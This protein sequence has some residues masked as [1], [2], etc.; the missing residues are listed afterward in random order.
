MHSFTS[1]LLVAL[2]GIVVSVLATESKVRG[3]KPS[4]IRWTFMGDKNP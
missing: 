4:K 2:G 1:S 3:F